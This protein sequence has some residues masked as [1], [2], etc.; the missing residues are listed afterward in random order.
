ME[1]HGWLTQRDIDVADKFKPGGSHD[2]ARQMVKDAMDG[3][4]VFHPSEDQLAYEF[5]DALAKWGEKYG[6]FAKVQL[7]GDP[8]KISA[9]EAV[10]KLKELRFESRSY[11]NYFN[12]IGDPKARQAA[13]AYDAAAKNLEDF[14]ERSAQ[15]AGKS[16]LVERLRDARKDIAKAHVVAKALN[17]ATGTVNPRVLAREKYLTG[18]L[19]KA[20][21]FAKAFPK[22][23]QSPEVMG[24]LP[25]ISPLDFVGGGIMGSVGQAAAG[26]PAGLLAAGVPFVRPFAR[27]LLLSDPYQKAMA[28]PSYSLGM[29][30]RVAGGL[31]QYAPVGATALGL[32][33][34]AQ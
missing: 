10:E 21:D 24:S 19:K 26:H 5:G 29:L 12:R 17:D 27:S 23:A 14:I 34:L 8:G 7:P 11:W 13:K 31:L 2:M 30:P 22:A 32:P 18:D 1:Q 9:K 15:K 25:G 33:A 3:N 16:D 28:N 6:S 4:P 20:A